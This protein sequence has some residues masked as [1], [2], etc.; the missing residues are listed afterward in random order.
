MPFLTG[1][2]W[3]IKNIESNLARRDSEV[4]RNRTGRYV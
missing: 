3:V 2:H 4:V 1:G